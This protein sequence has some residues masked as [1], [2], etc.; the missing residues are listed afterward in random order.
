VLCITLRFFPAVLRGRAE[1]GVLVWTALV[2][3]L[4]IFAGDLYR[5]A[6]LCSVSVEEAFG[7]ATTQW[8]GADFAV[9]QT[10][11]IT[12][13][14]FYSAIRLCRLVWVVVPAAVLYTIVTA[15]SYIPDDD[16]DM[17]VEFTVSR[18]LFSI[19]AQLLLD[20]L[21]LAGKYQIE[22]YR[23]KNYLSLEVTQRAIGARLERLNDM[24]SYEGSVFFFFSSSSSEIGLMSSELP[25]KIARLRGIGEGLLFEMV[26]SR[27]VEKHLRRVQVLESTINAFDS[28]SDTPLTS[29]IEGELKFGS[30]FEID[31]GDAS[32]SHHSFGKMVH[33][34]TTACRRYR[35]RGSDYKPKT[36]GRRFYYGFTEDA[37][38]TD[39]TSPNVQ[40]AQKSAL[41]YCGS[42]EHGAVEDAKTAMDQAPP[43]RSGICPLTLEAISE[44]LAE[45]SAET[46]G[47][48]EVPTLDHR[49]MDIERL[50][51]RAR[52][53]GS[54]GYPEDNKYLL[55]DVEHAQET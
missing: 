3:L 26:S 48:N 40:P 54:I 50:L 10:A 28:N 19:V 27:S 7:T 4:E 29:Q 52:Q 2:V 38:H 13:L 37:G 44:A 6:R 43:H 55:E 11:L 45:N 20:A 18:A 47:G 39:P 53:E 34:T 5:A 1:V 36:E 51:E 32:Q 31:F 46:D 14:A 41:Y 16:V 49:L 12:Y 21:A 8:R 9:L 23:R 30:L 35:L 42:T 33:A 22:M 15:M 24:L 25:K 17:D